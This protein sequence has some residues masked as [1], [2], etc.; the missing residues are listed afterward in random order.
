MGQIRCDAVCVRRLRQRAPGIVVPAGYAGRRR[1]RGRGPGAGLHWQH[2]WDCQPCSYPDRTG[3]LRSIVKIADFYSARQWHSI[4]MYCG[5][6]RPQGFEHDLMLY[7][8]RNTRPGPGPGRTVRLISS[9][10]P[11]RTSPSVTGRCS[12]CC[13]RTCTR[14]TWMPS[15]AATPSPGS[16]PGKGTATPGGRRAHQHPDRPPAEHHGGNRGYPPGKH[17]RRLHVSSRIV[18]VARGV[19]DQVV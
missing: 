16:P 7:P 1:G 4:G 18:A 19:L 11:A 8:A 5:L 15:G 12:P 9:A 10:G 14:P 3:D 17:L 2:Y 13:A 6:N